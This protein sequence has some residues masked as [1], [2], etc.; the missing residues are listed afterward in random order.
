MLI[1]IAVWNLLVFLLYGADKLVAI[2][3][4][5]RVPEAWLI[6]TSIIA[7]GVGGAIGMIVFHHK[8]SK[9]KFRIIIPLALIGTIGIIIHFFNI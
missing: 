2:K 7:G 3:G 8:I 4:G 1:Y 5:R 6:I 9:W